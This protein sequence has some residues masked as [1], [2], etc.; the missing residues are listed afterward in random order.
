MKNADI[1]WARLGI[2]AAAAF[3]LPI[4]HALINGGSLPGAARLGLGLAIIAGIGFVQD[5][6]KVVAEVHP[7]E[8]P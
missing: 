2:N 1:S 8:V 4:A 3:L 6:R 7:P 5:P